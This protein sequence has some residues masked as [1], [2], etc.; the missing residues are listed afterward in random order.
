MLISFAG[1]KPTERRLIKLPREKVRLSDIVVIDDKQYLVV[2]VINAHMTFDGARTKII[3]WKL[4]D[5]A[6]RITSQNY[7]ILEH[8]EVWRKAF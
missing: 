2:K 5:K 6:S 1:G 4:K 8:Y 7:P 3:E